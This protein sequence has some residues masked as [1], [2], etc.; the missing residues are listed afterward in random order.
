MSRYIFK[1]T[2]AK[3]AADVI[4]GLDYYVGYDFNSGTIDE[5]LSIAGLKAK[6]SDLPVGRNSS[7]KYIPIKD[8]DKYLLKYY[9]N[10]EY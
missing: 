9:L 5:L 1:N 2:N 7:P 8:Y 4:K 3:Q 6:S 10:E